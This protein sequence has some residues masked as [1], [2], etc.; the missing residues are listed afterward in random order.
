[1]SA[2]TAG[3]LLIVGVCAG[4]GGSLM[5]AA[6]LITLPALLA[7]GLPPQA[8]SVSTIIGQTPGGLTGLYGYR[9]QL[10]RDRRLLTLLLA[11]MTTGS[12]LGGVLL[13]TVPADWLD[14][15]I[16]C[17]IA[18]ATA[19]IA[20]QPLLRARG[21]H[22]RTRPGAALADPPDACRSQACPPAGEAGVALREDNRP[23]PHP[24]DQCYPTGRLIA[25][26]A[27]S[28]VYGGWLSVCLGTVI[29]GLVGGALPH[30][31]V[32]QL[33]AI[34]MLLSTAS[35][36]AATAVFVASGVAH[37]PTIAM[38][39]TG[40]LLGGWGGARIGQRLPPLLLRALIVA[41]GVAST[42]QAL[43]A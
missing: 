9:R 40:T 7:L 22:R 37:W 32:Q 42:T 34:R 26:A 11:A 30:A 8:A 39:G 31:S 6:T 36:A 25:A 14:H 43:I 24:A 27:A 3:L 5:G 33:N 18:A 4:V 19:F 38:I 13:V 41:V 17:A 15:L 2:A 20:A 10:P 29:I 16:P 1:M 35:S 23:A 28:G 21:R 12:A